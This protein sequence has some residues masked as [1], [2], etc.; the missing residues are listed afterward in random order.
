MKTFPFCKEQVHA[1]AIKCRFCHSM[2]V[3]LEQPKA[4]D[5]GR[6][7]YILD[8][9]LVRFAKFTAAV[10][11]VFLVVGAYLFGF[12][13]DSALEKVRSTQQDLTAA[14]EKMAGAQKELQAAQ[15]VTVKLKSDV[16]RVLA[17]AQRA[18][19][20]ISSQRTLAIDIVASMRELGL[21]SASNIQRSAQR[22]RWT[23]A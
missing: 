2:L 3:P 17:E 5:D 4:Q 7:T 23:S 6:V 20:E 11:A 19:G 16:E 10:L 14:Q 21:M 8:R 22:I 1:D 12:K 9:D 13:L 18:V 15:A